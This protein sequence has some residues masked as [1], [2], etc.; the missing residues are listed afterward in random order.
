MGTQAK[1]F[2]LPIYSF[3]LPLLPPIHTQGIVHSRLP[4]LTPL[5]STENFCIGASTQY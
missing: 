2:G 3:N 1:K 5:L 4:Q